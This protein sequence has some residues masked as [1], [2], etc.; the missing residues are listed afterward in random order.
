[1]NNEATETHS[2]VIIQSGLD[3]GSPLAGAQEIMH[4]DEGYSE[5]FGTDE[6]PNKSV[7]SFVEIKVLVIDGWLVDIEMRAA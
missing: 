6:D 3:R 5:F 4:Y 7:R 1:M 2:G